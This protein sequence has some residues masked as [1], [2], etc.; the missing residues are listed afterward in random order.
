MGNDKV[1]TI[2]CCARTSSSCLWI[3]LTCFL[4]PTV[5]FLRRT[6]NVQADGELHDAVFVVGA[7][8]E[9]VS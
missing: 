4:F 2:P 5:G 1:S 8:D 6:E 3:V 7:L 9:T